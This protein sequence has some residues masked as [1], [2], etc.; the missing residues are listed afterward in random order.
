MPQQ[1]WSAKMKLTDK[2]VWSCQ[3]KNIHLAEQSKLEKL[4]WPISN[5]SALNSWLCFLPG[6]YKTQPAGL[7]DSAS[8]DKESAGM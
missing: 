6:P 7:E 8:K 1:L 4:L 5:I 2:P 3:Q